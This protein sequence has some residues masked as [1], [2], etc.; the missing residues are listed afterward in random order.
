MDEF[1]EFEVSGVSWEAIS[2]DAQARREKEAVDGAH[3][4]TV[5]TEPLDFRRSIWA[6]SETALRSGVAADKKVRAPVA[7]FLLVLAAFIAPLLPASAASLLLTGATVH[8]ISGETLSLGQVLIQDGKIAAVGQS[9]S[10]NGAP[11]TNLSGLHLYPGLIS[12]NSVLGLVEIS[13]VRATLDSTEVGEYTPDVESWIAVNPDSELIAVARANGIAYF[14]PVPKGGIVPGQSGL[15]TVEG[16]TSENRTIKKPVAL[17]LFWPSMELETTQ[18]ARARTKAKSIEEQA[19]DRRSKLRAIEEFFLEARHYAKAKDAAGKGSALAPEIVPAWEAMLPYVR[20]QLPIM[21]HADEVRQIRAAV[22]WAT[23]NKYSI[24]LA[25]GRDSW[26]VASLL[27][28]NKI[29]VI[30]SSTFDL[31]VRDTA[32]YDVHFRAVEVLRQAGEKVAFSIGLDGMEAPHARNL[33]YNA[34]QAVAFG[35]P[36]SEAL[37]GLTLYPAQIAGASDRLGSIEAGKDATLFAADDDIL[38]LRANVRHMWISGKEI[39][40]ENKQTRL[41]EKYKSRPQAN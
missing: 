31:P 17:H 5:I 41:Y 25:G 24:I 19:K 9:V 6:C 36:E 3:L 33:P 37:K 2:A 27:S 18:R 38:D 20:G 28:T 40:L 26:M 34:A 7:V 16:W 8:T 29:P 10:A 32:S 15:V 23:T 39:S 1:E 13:G 4:D 12:L 22:E 14:E 21:V 30:Y 35:L 11:T